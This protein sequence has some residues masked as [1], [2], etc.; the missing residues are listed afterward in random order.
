M[1]YSVH[2]GGSTYTHIQMVR[3]GVVVSFVDHM[4]RCRYLVK[5]TSLKAKSDCNGL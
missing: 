4:Q 5:S 3:K 1:L 2:V